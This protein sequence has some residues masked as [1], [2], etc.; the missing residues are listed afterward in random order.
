[1][2]LSP[3][4]SV[5]SPISPFGDGSRTVPLD[6]LGPLPLPCPESEPHIPLPPKR[7]FSPVESL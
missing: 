2:K 6:F 7:K 5:P 3:S 4:R 1:M